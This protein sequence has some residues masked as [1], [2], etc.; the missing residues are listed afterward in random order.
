MESLEGRI[1][2]R[3]IVPTLKKRKKY[4]GIEI[5]NPI[6]NLK[7]KTADIEAIQQMTC[8]FQEAFQFAV[9]ERDNHGR[10]QALKDEKTG[11]ILS[12]DCGYSNLEFS[13]GKG[14][15]LGELSDRL[16]EYYSFVQ[17]QLAE[18][19]HLLTG[20]GVNPQWS[21]NQN[22]PIENSRYMMLF[23]YLGS[24]KRYE[25]KHPGFFH[26][27][28]SYGIFTSASQVQID[29]DEPDLIHTIKTFERLEPVKALLLANSVLIDE[30]WKTLIARDQLWEHSMHGIFPEN[31]G[32]LKHEVR[33]TEEYADYLTETTMFCAQRGEKYYSFYPIPLKEYLLRP[34][35]EGEYYDFNKREFIKEDFQ[36]EPSDIEYHRTYLYQDLTTRGTIEYRSGCAQPLKD[37][38]TIAAFHVGIT[39]KLDEVNEVLDTAPD[40]FEQTGSTQEQRKVFSRRFLPDSADQKQ[41]SDYL[42]AILTVAHAGLV[43]RG[44]GEERFLQPLFERAG[45]NT[46]PAKELLQ[47]LEKGERLESVMQ[48]YSR[49]S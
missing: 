49:L 26:P 2:E 8:A 40:F 14:D 38:M 41:V 27:Y 23:H 17:R 15:H 37:K 46:N 1:Y 12:Y 10:I 30:D 24:F 9:T 45:A 19:N 47:R 22:I 28:P 13:L 4:I 34:S 21:S 11:D 7:G 25:K 18:R 3:Y 42:L 32:L 20:F 48:Q 6:V 39:E 35:I 31:V 5:E 36:P 43:L 29:V 44:K 16:D 33:T